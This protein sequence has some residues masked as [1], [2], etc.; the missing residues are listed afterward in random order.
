MCLVEKDDADD[1][2]DEETKAK[3]IFVDN[4]Q[5]YGAIWLLAT[6]GKDKMRDM[7]VVAEN[8]WQ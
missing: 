2:T 1:I 5:D 8:V 7:H 6:E 4:E 3:N